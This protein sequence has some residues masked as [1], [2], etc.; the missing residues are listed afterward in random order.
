[1]ASPLLIASAALAI[2]GLSAL[3]R[4]HAYARQLRLQAVQA[5]PGLPPLSRAKA[6]AVMHE[7]EKAA[8]REALGGL[9]E[10]N[11]H[12]EGTRAHIIWAGHHGATLLGWDQ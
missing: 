3:K 5:N 1:M 6:L 10:A 2:A 11:P 7:A 12:P 8:I 4:R 9:A